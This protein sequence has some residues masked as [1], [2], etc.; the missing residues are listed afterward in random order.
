[1]LSYGVRSLTVFLAMF[2][3]GLPGQVI[4]QGDEDFPVAASSQETLRVQEKAAS[5][6]D[7][8]KYERSYF[9]YRNE[10]VPI[11][12]KYAQY[13]VGFM[14]LTGLG[15][16]EDRVAAAAWYRLAAER[17]TKEFVMVR[18]QLMVSLTPEQM[19]DCDR[20]FV[21]LR[22]QYGDLAILMQSV[23]EDMGI[24]K[25]RTGSRLG[26]RASPVAVIDMTRGGAIGSGD[27]YYRKVEERLRTRLQYIAHKAKIEIHDLNDLD[28]ATIEARVAER[29]ESPN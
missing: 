29:L 4:A 11:G 17:G 24:L 19:E 20:L 22:K 10:L 9:I 2:L 15:T 12:D 28:I 26:S 16:T 14:H 5:L 25:E 6:F 13:M 3:L 1:M 18:K 21:E 7:T 23:R 8:G 27:E